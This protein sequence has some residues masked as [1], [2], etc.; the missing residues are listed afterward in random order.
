MAWPQTLP[1]RWRMAKSVMVLSLAAAEGFGVWADR[2]HLGEE[3]QGLTDG[4]P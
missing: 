1:A 3:R 4:N 2:R